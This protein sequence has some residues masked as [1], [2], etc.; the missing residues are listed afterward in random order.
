MSNK[1]SEN[2]DAVF[3]GID[4]GLK[5]IG[6]AIS[7][8]ITKKASPLAIIYNKRNIINWNELDQIII[9]WSPKI[10][11]VGQPAVKKE[12]NFTRALDSFNKQLSERYSDRLKIIKYSEEYT[13]EESKGLYREMRQN[14]EKINK[15]YHLDDVSASI[16]LQ[17]WLN[18]NMIS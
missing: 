16:I 2:D 8:N 10:I 15:K 9:T 11:I 14:H 13:T 5:K 4:F 18:E 6:V 17:S 12:N 3:F 1:Y 7:Q